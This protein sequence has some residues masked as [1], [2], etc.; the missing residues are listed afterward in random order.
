M[1]LTFIGTYED[2]EENG[3]PFTVITFQHGPKNRKDQYC[4]WSFRGDIQYFVYTS[5]HA[6]AEKWWKEDS[7]DI[8]HQV[9]D[10]MVEFEVGKWNR[11]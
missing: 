2:K 5:D 11:S 8:L 9:L 10:A 4:W 7:T 1:S 3:R 6:Q